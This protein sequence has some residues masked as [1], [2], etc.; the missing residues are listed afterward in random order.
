MSEFFKIRLMKLKF[1]LFGLL[2]CATLAAN[3]VQVKKCIGECTLANVTPEAAKLKALEAAKVNALEKAGVEQTINVAATLQK[4]EVNTIVRDVFAQFSSMEM[5]G[6]IVDYTIISDTILYRLGTPV[7][8]VEIDATVKKYQKAPN[9]LLQIKV[10]GMKE[11]YNSGD[12]VTF[13]VTSVYDGYLKIFL[14]DDNEEAAL[15]FPNEHEKLFPFEEGK[16]VHYPTNGNITYET[17][18]DAGKELEH[19]YWVFVFTRENIPFIQDVTY[20]NILNWIYAM[21]PDQRVVEFR[22]LIIR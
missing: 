4:E 16:T 18:K 14:L 15:I 22:D 8:R 7:C 5:R 12:A 21:E 13:D 19:N 17:T 9:R 6:G 2:M 11:V 20:K 10:D 1:I 3:T